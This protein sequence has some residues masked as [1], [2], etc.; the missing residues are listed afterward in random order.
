[1]NILISG[2]SGFIGQ[3]LSQYLQDAQGTEQ[4]SQYSDTHITWLTRDASQPHPSFVSLMSYEQL[5]TTQSTFDVI[6]NLAGAGIADKRW[7]DERKQLL[8]QSR[9]KPTQALLDYIS[10]TLVKPK[11]LLSGSAIGWYGDQGE[12]PLDESSRFEDKGDADFAHQLCEAWE[13]KAKQALDFKVPVV[14]L[15][16][17]IV[18]HPSGGMLAKILPAFKMGLGGQLGDGNQIMSWISLNDWVRAA[19]HI[20]A[21]HTANKHYADSTVYNLTAPHPL[22]NAV[23]TQIVGSW[24]KRPTFM[25]LPKAV[26]KLMFGEM[27]GLLIEGQKVLPK[28]LLDTGFV[29][30]HTALKQALMAQKLS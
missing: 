12:T 23:F 29:F 20:M 3:T 1:M 15:R 22:S 2:G 14:I 17:G 16:T 6:V 9:L 25:T 21:Q 10:R 24:L 13:A 26:L 5:Q 11:L 30:K 28:H 4:D 7:S 19:V 27:S 8:L 18:I